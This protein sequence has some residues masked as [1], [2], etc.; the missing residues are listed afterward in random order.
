VQD[1]SS[2]NKPLSSDFYFMESEEEAVR[3]DIKTDPAAVRDQALWCGVVPG[4]RVLDA[5]C[6]AGIT[7][8]ILGQMVHPGGSVLGLDY[9]RERIEYAAA[10]YGEGGNIAFELHDLRKPLDSHGSFDLIWIRFVLEYH[11]VGATDIVSNLIKAL[12]PGGCLCLLDLDFNCLI[13]YELPPVT[14]KMLDE[15]MKAVDERFNFDTFIGRKLYSFLYDAGMQNISV[16][17]RAHN[18]FYGDMSQSSKFNLTKKIETAGW[19]VDDLIS[20]S[21]PGGY[22]GLYNDFIKYL[23]DPRRFSYTPLIMCRG[24]KPAGG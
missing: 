10:H 1:N 22:Q 6:G 20:S 23:N 8:S 21:Y 11:R 13:H 14:M 17:L 5:G 19:A 4:I 2:G 15:I 18:L 9:S 7:T 12:K 16:E 3:L 24:Y